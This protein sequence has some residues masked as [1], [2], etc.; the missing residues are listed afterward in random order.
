[1][2]KLEDNKLGPDSWVVGEC[3]RL[4]GLGF[5]V[6]VLYG[7]LD[8]GLLGVS[9]DLLGQFGLETVGREGTVRQRSTE[10]AA[11]E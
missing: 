11:C 4:L 6:Q 1:M 5:L 10:R 9:T 7:A 2:G 8:P 3:S